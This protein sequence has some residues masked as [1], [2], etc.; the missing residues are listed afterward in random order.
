MNINHNAIIIGISSDIGYEI[1]KRYSELKYTIVGTYKSQ[2]Y[3][4]K[5]SEINDCQCYYCDISNINDIKAFKDSVSSLNKK[6]DLFISSVGTQKPIDKFFDCDFDEWSESIHTNAIEQ[7][8]VLH[9]LYPYRNKDKIVDVVFFAGSGTNGPAPNYSAYTVSKIM[10][11]K[12]CELLDSEYEDINIFI[13]GPG[14]VKT[15]IHQETLD[16]KKG[17]GNNYYRTVKFVEGGIPA[18]SYDDIFD[19]IEWLRS[20]GREVVGGRNFSVVND[21]WGEDDNADALT[22][23]LLND[24]N[25]YKLR[26]HGNDDII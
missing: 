18:T 10:L 3:L 20:K 1:A 24:I 4:Q 9:E 14:W 22:Q 21:K 16:N 13:I 26:R 19:C 23:V 25:M 11:I 17:A 7:L 5:I 2:S 15:K 6:W 8:R 12:M